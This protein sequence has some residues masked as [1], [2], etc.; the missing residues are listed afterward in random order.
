MIEEKL[1]EVVEELRKESERW[2]EEYDNFSIEDIDQEAIEIFEKHGFKKIE[3]FEGNNQ[4][5]LYVWGDHGLEEVIDIDKRMGIIE[6]LT[7]NN[8]K[9]F[10]NIEAFEFIDPDTDKKVGSLNYVIYYKDNE[11]VIVK[12]DIR[13]G[14][15]EL[16][17]EVYELL[18]VFKI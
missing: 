4:R 16:D 15:E 17:T 12:K 3:K 18:G 1:K 14:L 11:V 7:S 13:F 9:E 6:Y 8:Y 5:R 2:N 10:D